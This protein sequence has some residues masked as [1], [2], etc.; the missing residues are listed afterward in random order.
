MFVE[1]SHIKGRASLLNFFF[2]KQDPWLTHYLTWVSLRRGKVANT[3]R[4]AFKLSIMNLFA[5]NPSY[6]LFDFW[7]ISGL[8][9]LHKLFSNPKTDAFPC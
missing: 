7:Y 4:Y 6:K 3:N 9:N 1:V 2:H 8:K 5:H